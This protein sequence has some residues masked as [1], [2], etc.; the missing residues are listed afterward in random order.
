VSARWLRSA[1]EAAWLAGDREGVLKAV[2]PAYEL[3]CQRRDPRMKGELAS[4]LWRVGALED[5]PTEI[6]DPYAQEICGDWR[7]AAFAWKGLGWPYEV[8]VPAGLARHRNG[9]AR[10]T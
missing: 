6:A 2:E 1:P 7:A 8:C 9:A 5:Q 4:W 3:V 10:G